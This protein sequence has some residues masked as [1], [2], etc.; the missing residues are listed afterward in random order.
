MN[1][2][3]ANCGLVGPD[4]GARNVGPYKCE[5]IDAQRA[6]LR[7]VYKATCG[8]CFDQL[9]GHVELPWLM[10]KYGVIHKAGST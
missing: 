2:Q 6:F 3:H 4:R 7:A 5:S 10:R 1:I 9:G 8:L